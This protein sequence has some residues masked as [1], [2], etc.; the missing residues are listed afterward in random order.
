[1]RRVGR[2]EREA[3]KV[4]GDC[5]LKRWLPGTGELDG[6]VL[7]CEER[8][9][10][11][12]NRRIKYGENIKTL[13]AKRAERKRLGGIMEGILKAAVD[14]KISLMRLKKEN[15]NSG[16]EEECPMK[17]IWEWEG[18]KS[19]LHDARGN[20]TGLAER[21][22]SNERVQRL[23]EVDK[24]MEANKDEGAERD[25]GRGENEDDENGENGDKQDDAK[26]GKQDEKDDKERK[27]LSTDSVCGVSPF[28]WHIPS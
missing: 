13:L 2:L 20:I 16:K 4:D 24:L 27:K 25:V 19:M 23:D 12:E 22:S 18:F 21:N 26:D 6:K 11:H 28:D 9:N 1:M 17:E 14:E 8:M 5:V 3:A 7:V 10:E 15:N